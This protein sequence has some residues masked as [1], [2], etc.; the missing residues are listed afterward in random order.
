MNI[1][2]VTIVGANGTMGANVSAIFA[3]FGNATVYMCCRDINKAKRAAEKAC[4][5]VRADSISERLIPVDFSKLEECVSKSDLV[6]ESTAE[7]FNIKSEITLRIGKS[8]KQNSIACTGSSGLSIT[9][10]AECLP[11]N[12]RKNYFGVHMFNPPYNMTLCELTPTEYSD[13]DVMKELR[14]YLTNKLYRTVVQVKDSPAFLANRI[15]FQFINEALIYAEKYKDNGGIDYID[16]ILG[17]FTGRAMPPLL[18][19]DFVGLDVTKA[20][21][22]NIYTTTKD[23]ANE[24][25]VV[26]D[27]V[28]KLIEKGFLGK[29]V[30]CG[31][32]KT[33]KFENGQKLIRVYDIATDTYRDKMKFIFPFAEQMKNY[34]SVGEYR[35]AIAVLIENKS[36]E[37]RIALNFLLKY[38]LYSIYTASTVGYHIRSADSVMATGFNWCPPLAMVELINTY[39][40][41]VKLV[42]ERQI[43][44]NIDK[45]ILDNLLSLIEP[46]RYDYRPFFKSSK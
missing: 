43:D 36:Q 9:K 37:A 26:P 33:S 7:N 4:K 35:E 25:F 34:I 6:F 11:N 28:N 17:P 14:E 3:S 2:V 13:L 45:S 38:V 18:T 41:F 44:L 40:D 22:D 5:S 46:S 27:Y 10:L 16:S 1:K 23:F 29:K 15:G 32:Y 19:A 24:S 21:D 31:L 20:I 8:L 30:G 42:Y 12:L 39:T